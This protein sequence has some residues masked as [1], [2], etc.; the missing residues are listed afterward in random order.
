MVYPYN[1]ENLS[2]KSHER[3][4][5]VGCDQFCTRIIIGTELSTLALQPHILVANQITLGDKNNIL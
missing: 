2:G 1:N 4:I 5:R 3:L